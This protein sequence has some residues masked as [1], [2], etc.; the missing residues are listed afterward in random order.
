VSEFDS[1]PTLLSSGTVFFS[2]ETLVPLVAALSPTIPLD[3]FHVS[4]EHTK[5]EL[6]SLHQFAKPTLF[7]PRCQEDSHQRPQLQ[8]AWFPCFVL[9]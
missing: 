6:S 5:K 3:A 9:D 2:L 8:F 4:Q 1:F 7:T